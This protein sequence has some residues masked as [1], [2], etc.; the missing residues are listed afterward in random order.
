M[1]KVAPVENALSLQ[2][3]QGRGQC[4]LRSV[5]YFTT[6]L[7]QTDRRYTGE[8]QDLNRPATL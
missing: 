1:A 5:R 7:T 3:P 8:C 6:Q 2:V 4:F